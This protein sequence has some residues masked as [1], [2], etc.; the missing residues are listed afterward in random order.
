MS[1]PVEIENLE[2]ALS[3]Y[4]MNPYLITTD[5]EAHPHIT[6]V[7]LS[8]DSAVFVCGL[9][10]KTS[11]NAL[12]RPSV[13]LLWPPLTPDSHSL[14]VDGVMEVID[15]EEGPQ[16]RI[17]PKAAILHR[18]AV[19]KDTDQNCDSDCQSITMEKER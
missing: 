15:T 8:K 6:H 14:I 3:E 2:T 5:N 11:A 10:K 12:E 16:G 18:P 4:G 1:I 9:G 13:A 7:T 19:K 17:A